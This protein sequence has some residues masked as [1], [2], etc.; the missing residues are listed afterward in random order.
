MVL[1][2]R[3]ESL[4]DKTILELLFDT[5]TNG[6]VGIFKFFLGVRSLRILKEHDIMDASHGV[7]GEGRIET[8]ISENLV[9]RVQKV[10]AINDTPFVTGGN[11]LPGCL[12]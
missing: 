3:I 5:G 9:I 1:C 2:H 7:D 6:G 4:T 8:R 11:Y 12:R 10:P